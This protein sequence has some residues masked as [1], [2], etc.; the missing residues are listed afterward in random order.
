[1]GGT[2]IVSAVSSEMPVEHCSA[3]SCIQANGIAAGGITPEADRRARA[4]QPEPAQAILE[5]PR[6]K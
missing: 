3:D 4:W 5:F 6:L 2:Q 1:L